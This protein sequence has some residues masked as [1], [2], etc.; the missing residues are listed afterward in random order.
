MQPIDIVSKYICTNK[1][2][3]KLSDY[4]LVLTILHGL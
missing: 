2:I 3:E 4:S 1:L